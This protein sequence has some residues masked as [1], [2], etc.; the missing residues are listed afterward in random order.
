MVTCVYTCVVF[1]LLC[2]S[3]SCTPRMS[4]P[5][6]SRWVAKLCRR[7]CGLVRGSSPACRRYPA[8]SR[9]TLR[10][11]S[12]PPSLFRK[13][14]GADIRGVQEL[15]GHKSLNTTQVYTHVTTQRL[16]TSYNKAHP[17]S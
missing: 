6:S 2:P 8:S 7:V 12:R 15:L 5:A 9:P 1:R 14:A 17:R 3:N 10:A 4:A 13:T 11:V 16:Q